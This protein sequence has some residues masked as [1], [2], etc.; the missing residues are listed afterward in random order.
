MLNNKVQPDDWIKV[1]ITPD[2]FEN[3]SDDKKSSDT[4]KGDEKIKEKK[5]KFFSSLSRGV[6]VTVIGM[7]IFNILTTTFVGLLIRNACEDDVSTISQIQNMTLPCM[8]EECNGTRNK[9]H[10]GMAYNCIS[11]ISNCDSTCES[12]LTN[13]FNQA[14]GVGSTI[15]MEAIFHCSRDEPKCG[16]NCQKNMVE[17]MTGMSI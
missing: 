6:I 10:Q 3:S 8:Y 5:K 11:S 13:C 14:V 16:N 12:D 9:E 2:D 4:E 7:L 1:N 17:C 15:F